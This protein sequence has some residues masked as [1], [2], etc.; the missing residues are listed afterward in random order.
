MPDVV[1][2]LSIWT[3]DTDKVVA[4]DLDDVKKVLQ[5]H[6]GSNEFDDEVNN[7]E[8][9]KVADDQP[10][11]IVTLDGPDGD[12]KITKTASEWIASDGRGFLCSTEF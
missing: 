3:N 6:C 5:G 4:V 8:W 10:I 1:N 7:G 9:Y 11:T 12:T 2:K